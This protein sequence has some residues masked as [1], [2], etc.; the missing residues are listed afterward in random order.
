MKILHVTHTD[1]TNDNRIH[2]QIKFLASHNHFFVSSIFIKSEKYNY[3]NEV[4]GVKNFSRKFILSR[5]KWIPRVFRHVFNIFEITFFIILKGFKIKPNVIHAHD[6]L[7]LPAATLLAVICKSKLIYDAHE[8]ESKR[9][10]QN[11]LMSYGSLFIEKIC[12]KRINK[13]ITVSDSILRWYFKE[14]STKDFEVIINSPINQYYKKNNYLREKF[15]IN[16]NSNVF[17]YIGYLSNGRGINNIL[18]AFSKTDDKNHIVFLGEGELEEKIKT[19]C[20]LNKN[21]HHHAPVQYDSVINIASSADVGICLI[22]NTCLSYYFALP[23]KLFEY[24]FSGI[25]VIGSDFPEIKKIITKCNAGVTC[26]N[27]DISLLEAINKIDLK[28][29]TI[30]LESLNWKSQEKKLLSLYTR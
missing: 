2:K 23:N 9:N 17:I 22:D 21:I 14:F 11:V 3:E 19:Y 28:E 12:W 5:H 15:K 7:V 25:K 29:E 30:N 10:G 20:N 13:F 24:I 4:T 1:V 27:N 16:Q 18:D 26:E 6:T 8:L